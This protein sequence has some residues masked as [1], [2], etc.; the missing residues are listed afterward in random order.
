MISSVRDFH[1]NF[2]LH[3]KIIYIYYPH[4]VN[5]EW[6]LP[7]QPHGNYS[8]ASDEKTEQLIPF[9]YKFYSRFR[10]STIS[11]E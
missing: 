7:Q 2:N 5:I 4:W 8:K 11:K 10:S 6:L 9:A 1:V 3:V